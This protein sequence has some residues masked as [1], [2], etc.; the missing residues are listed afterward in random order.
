MLT[1]F[2]PSL[3]VKQL[4][5]GGRK[6]G[7]DATTSEL[8]LLSPCIA[9]SWH[10]SI[11][12]CGVFVPLTTEN[13]YP[14]E[15][16]ENDVAAG[17]HITEVRSSNDLKKVFPDDIATG[18]DFPSSEP[19]LSG[20]LNHEGGWAE[21]GRALEMLLERVCVAGA[22]VLAGKEVSEVMREGA[23]S[24]S[25][26]PLCI[27]GVKCTDGSEYHAPTVIVAAG[28]WTPRLVQRLGVEFAGPGTQKPEDELVQQVGV[29]LATG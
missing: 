8:V 3:L 29:G 16:H 26:A 2:T 18:F 9:H 17:A 5:S 12:R 13:S 6:S 22:Q 20:Y 4:T 15:A 1:L 19:E 23:A 27:T 28:A 24:D 21:S 14:K 11:R 10:S 25:Q 7:R